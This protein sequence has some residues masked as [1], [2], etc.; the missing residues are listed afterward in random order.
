MLEPSPITRHFLP[1]KQPLLVP[2]AQYLLAL[3]GQLK[4]CMVVV[5]TTH[6]GRQLRQTLPTLAGHAVLAPSVVTPE[7]LFSPQDTTKA[8]SKIEWWSAWS[9]TLR[10]LSEE[11]LS[12][13]FPKLNEIERDFTWGLKAAMRFCK[14]KEEVGSVD[15]SFSEVAEHSEEASRWLQLAAIDSLVND[16]LSQRN[17]CCPVETKRKAS[18]HWKAPKGVKRIILACVPNL[19]QLARQSLNQ[20][21]L[22][23]DLLIHADETLSKHFD[24]WGIPVADYW[25]SCHLPL[26]SE[27]TED[28][29]QIFN[30]GHAASEALI[31]DCA[32]IPSDHIAL[33]VTDPS[34]TTLVSDNFTQAGWKPFLPEGRGVAKSGLWAFLRQLRFALVNPHNF[35]A[36]PSILKSPEVRTLLPSLQLP[37]QAAKEIDELTKNHLP[38]SLNHAIGC[39]SETIKEPLE[40]LQSFLLS[41]RSMKASAFIE[42][43]FDH[44]ERSTDFPSELIDPF[45]GAIES[46]Q[47]LELQQQEIDAHHALDLVMAACE[48]VRVQSDHSGTALD[49]LG[50]F[51]LAYANEPHLRILGFHENFVPERPHDDGFLPESLRDKI[52]L[53]SRS[54]L[55][56]RDS[57]LFHSLV[58][59]R[60]DT[61]SV[62][63]F[64]CQ[65]TPS[66]EE[67]QASRLLMRCPDDQLPARVQH[68]FD[69]KIENK[70][71]LPA[72][73]SGDW[74]LKLDSPP[75]WPIDKELI[76]SPSKLRSFLHC[77]FRFYLSKV[78]GF[79]RESIDGQELDAAQFG[80]LV[81]DTLEAYGRDPDARDLTD[82]K[83][84]AQHFETLL[85]SIFVQKYGEATNL[86]LSI[87]HESALRRLKEFADEQAQLRQDGWQIKYVELAIGQADN[88]I[89]WSIFDTP[90]SMRIDRIDVHETTRQWRVI[91]Y[92]TSKKVK[93]PADEHLKNLRTIDEKEHCYGEPVRPAGER[94]KSPRRW[95]NLQLPLYAAFA[96]EHFGLTELPEVGYVSFPAAAIATGLQL[97]DDYDEELHESAL[98][99]TQNAI[100]AIRTG[101]FPIRELPANAKSWDDFAALHPVNLEQAFSF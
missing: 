65:S 45:L 18:N 25:T 23:I 61:G 81:H 56:A 86:P 22:P 13:I 72:Y 85:N 31:S 69:E 90:V 42:K 32:D 93:L 34:F 51:E 58:S 6:S 46:L 92:K 88:E 17:L 79:N 77:P 12:A 35:H 9:E 4:D 76:V 89:S 73:D 19:P 21:M 68:C 100:A 2:L 62:R 8:A 48:G 3:G 10:T 70:E 44:L 47:Q 53:Y 95:E 28:T 94:K 5:P 96:K 57:F 7:V 99:W 66:G 67:R 27:S 63:F 39:A 87:Q 41:A 82:P 49:Q 75:A 55:E 37:T 97:W 52:G 29:I 59:A 40:Q 16:L 64:L 11:E 78:E 84:I 54:Q 33:S 15:Y 71:I 101:S 24:Q 50:W 1:T 36:I 30:S 26:P 43:L 20:S 14:L 80:N 98:E 38:Q 83:L 60:K 74:Q 91:D